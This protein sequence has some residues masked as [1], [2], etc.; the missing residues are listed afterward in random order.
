MLKGNSQSTIILASIFKK[1]PE[2]IKDKYHYENLNI[3]AGGYI[4]GNPPLSA[5]ILNAI[6]QSASKLKLQK[7]HAVKSVPK[8]PYSDEFKQQLNDFK[9]NHEQ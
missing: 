1:L 3:K 8:E 6:H 4:L 7:W 9:R 2:F 5:E